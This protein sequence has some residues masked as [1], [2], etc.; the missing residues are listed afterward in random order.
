[1]N[2]EDEERIKLKSIEIHNIG[3]IGHFKEEI[4]KPLT[5]FLVNLSK[6][7]ALLLKHYHLP[8]AGHTQKI[9]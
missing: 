5:I 3:I 9:Y 4:N 1:M 7:K 6:V 8:V 2:N